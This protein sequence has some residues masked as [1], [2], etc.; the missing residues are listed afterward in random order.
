MLRLQQRFRPPTESGRRWYPATAETDYAPRLHVAA[1]A[2]HVA[3]VG[4]RVVA[5]L[6]VVVVDLVV[7]A[8]RNRLVIRT[9]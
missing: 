8:D 6:V 1:A 3:A 4:L 5:D 7:V 2:P 9:P